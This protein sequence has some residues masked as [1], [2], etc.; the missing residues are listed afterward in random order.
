MFFDDVLQHRWIKPQLQILTTT[1]QNPYPTDYLFPL[2]VW[3]GRKG[4]QRADILL[5]TKSPIDAPDAIESVEA[6]AEGTT[7]ELYLCYWVCRSRIAMKQERLSI[8][9]L[10]CFF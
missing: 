9:N 7:P 1:F 6:A 5:V 4:A 8:S 2:G 10:S 3:E